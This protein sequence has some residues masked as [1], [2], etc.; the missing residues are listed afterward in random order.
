MT[1]TDSQRRVR[2]N[3]KAAE[4]NTAG[5]K[6]PDFNQDTAASLPIDAP[7]QIGDRYAQ[8]R[9]ENDNNAALA[10]KDA[11]KNAKTLVA[12]VHEVARTLAFTEEAAIASLPA[13][14]EEYRAE[15]RSMFNSARVNTRVP[16]SAME[17]LE[18]RVEDILALRPTPFAP[19]SHRLGVYQEEFAALTGYEEGDVEV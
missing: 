7:D 12:S 10:V 2:A 3:R 4:S 1:L 8:V 17:E 13:L 15:Y 9:E 19:S 6:R 16:F 18:F 5:D 14:V 11:S